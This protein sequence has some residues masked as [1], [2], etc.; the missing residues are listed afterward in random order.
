VSEAASAPNYIRIHEK[1]ENQLKMVMQAIASEEGVDI[2]DSQQ[3]Y[4][5]PRGLS[6]QIQ[7]RVRP[8]EGT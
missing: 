7:I 8:K 6:L 5:S 4:V 3:V 2:F 1:L